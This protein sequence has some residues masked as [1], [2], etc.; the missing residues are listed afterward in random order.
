MY[1]H[2]RYPYYRPYPPVD[3]EQFTSAA[4]H[5]EELLKEGEQIS[6]KVKN[7]Q[8][9]ATSLMSAAQQSKKDE[10][11]QLLRTVDIHSEMEVSFTPDSLSIRLK[12][13]DCKAKL[14]YKW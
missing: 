6:S 4:N 14:V 1:Y 7:S 8:S 9:F 5:M 10:V 11:E 3:P 12:R 13:D 2:P